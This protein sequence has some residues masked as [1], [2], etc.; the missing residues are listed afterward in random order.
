MAANIEA[1]LDALLN[2]VAPAVDQRHTVHALFAAAEILN[3]DLRVRSRYTLA[4]F[5]HRLLASAENFCE[6]KR[7]RMGLCADICAVFAATLA[8]VTCHG[9]KVA[10]RVAQREVDISNTH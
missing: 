1:E 2:R 10:Q 9:V 7:V 3:A 8:C 4:E 5:A 6:R